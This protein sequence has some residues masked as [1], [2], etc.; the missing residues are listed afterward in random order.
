MPALSPTWAKNIL[1]LVIGREFDP[2]DLP[3]YFYAALYIGSPAPGGGGAEV[4]GSG[5]NGYARVEVPNDTTAWGAAVDPGQKGNLVAVTFGAPTADWATDAT[6]I[7]HWALHTDPA[8]DT[9]FTYGQL[10]TPRAVLSGG[11]PVNFAP[12]ALVI[13]AA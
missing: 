10:A 1:D 3:D 13:A 7:S 12:G 2:A 9:L 6:P 5:G 8:T 4:D 11:T